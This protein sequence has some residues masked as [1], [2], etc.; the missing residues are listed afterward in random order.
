MYE[1]F[2]GM[3][4]IRDKII[5]VTKLLWMEFLGENFNGI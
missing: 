2:E 1:N 5:H 4:Y 3:E